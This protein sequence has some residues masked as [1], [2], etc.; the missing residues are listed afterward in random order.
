MTSEKTIVAIFFLAL[1]A[2]AA[3]SAP[4]PQ[5]QV[6]LSQLNDQDFVKRKIRC[7]LDELPCDPLGQR[8]KDLLPEILQSN[9][10]NCSPFVKAN[11]TR[12]IRY[13]Q[14]RYPKEWSK[15]KA[16]YIKH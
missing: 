1:M 5:T 13:A 7:V 6:S 10:A 8:L 14:L 4:A 9:C 11:V 15:I 16:K 2:L 12:L 3:N